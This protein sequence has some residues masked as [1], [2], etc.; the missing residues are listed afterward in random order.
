MHIRSRFRSA[1]QSVC[2]TDPVGSVHIDTAPLVGILILVYVLVR[3]AEDIQA[4]PC[5]SGAAGAG[6]RP[7]Y[8]LAVGIVVVRR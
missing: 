3:D 7:Q 2:V 1:V 8:E 6:G 4:E 5:R